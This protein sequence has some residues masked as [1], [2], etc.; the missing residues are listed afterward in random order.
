MSTLSNTI[1]ENG[2]DCAAIIIWS[3]GI[4]GLPEGWVIRKS[5]YRGLDHMGRPY[6]QVYYRSKSGFNDC[7]DCVR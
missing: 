3:A 1:H 6:I 2:P 4:T 7:F 5:V